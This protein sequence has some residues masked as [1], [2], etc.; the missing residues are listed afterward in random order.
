MK[1]KAACILVIIFTFIMLTSCSA[2]RNKKEAEVVEV[3]EDLCEFML[4]VIG[5]DVETAEKMVEKKYGLTLERTGPEYK[6]SNV[7][8]KPNY[9]SYHYQATF[10][11]Q[12]ITFSGLS[13]EYS[14]LNKSREDGTVF[15][16]GFSTDSMSLKEAEE[17]YQK[18]SDYFYSKL[19]ITAFVNTDAFDSDDYCTSSSFVKDGY[20]YY[21]DYYYSGHHDSA[22]VTVYCMTHDEAYY[23]F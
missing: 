5:K 17:C 12:G 7:T 23:V 15:R 8:N 16:I 13:L 6:N 22:S 10:T 20:T 4:S 19:G 9:D 14:H 18:F 2:I 21:V 3:P 1:K 11:E